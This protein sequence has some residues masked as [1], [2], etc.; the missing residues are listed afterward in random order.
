MPDGESRY[1]LLAT[2]NLITMATKKTTQTEEPVE[3]TTEQTAE[4]TAEVPVE[5]PA[6]ATVE[7]TTEAP[8]EQEV[9]QPAEATAETTTEAPAEQ[10]VEQPAEATAEGVVVKSCNI[11]VY[12]E[13]GQR[14]LALHPKVN[15]VYVTSDGYAFLSLNAAQNNARN[16]R[17]HKV[18]VVKR[19]ETNL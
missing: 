9:E 11:A 19:E 15:E 3:Q 5:Q 16:L 13:V 8:A 18:F 2:K 6:E 7:T 12:N 4:A 17:G 14:L 1:S 10:E